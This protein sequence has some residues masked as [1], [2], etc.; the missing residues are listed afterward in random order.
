MSPSEYHVWNKERTP[1]RVAAVRTSTMSASQSIKL[2]FESGA[3]RAGGE[4][5]TRSTDYAHW[6]G[7]R[8]GDVYSEAQRP[9]PAWKT[10]SDS[11]VFVVA[12]DVKTANRKV[13]AHVSGPGV[14]FNSKFYYR[15]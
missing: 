3:K 13:G 11:S 15:K 7:G 2:E 4:T 6:R 12:A 10:A 5:F 14:G 9:P 8:V 1:D